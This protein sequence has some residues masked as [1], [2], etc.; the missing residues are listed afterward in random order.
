M[1]Q[2][3]LA[4][5][6]H[7]DH[8]HLLIEMLTRPIRPLFA[9]A[10]LNNH[11]PF[12]TTKKKDKKAVVVQ[13]EHDLC[14]LDIM[15]SCLNAGLKSTELI[16]LILIMQN[17]IAKNGKLKDELNYF[18]L[19]SL[20]VVR[21]KIKLLRFLFVQKDF[22]FSV[23]LFL[24]TLDLEAYDIAALLHK[25]FFRMIRNLKPNDLEEIINCVI[26]SFNKSNGMIDFKCY[27]ARQ[28]IEKMQ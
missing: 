18:E 9:P 14:F 28:F 27:L 2:D 5:L 6:A 11:K 4:L 23:G 1:T 8:A 22:R 26:Q 21:R 7:E 20:F 24:R 10:S 17:E 13:T 3:V 16:N 15:E 25:E 19:F 12:T